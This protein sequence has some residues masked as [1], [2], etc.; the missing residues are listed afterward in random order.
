MLK[1]GAGITKAIHNA[2]KVLIMKIIT[3]N[4]ICSKLKVWYFK[5]PH[6]A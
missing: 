3:L 1:K 5:I 4:K 2:G 6:Y